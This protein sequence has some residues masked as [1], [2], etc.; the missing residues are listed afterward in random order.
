MAVADLLI[1]NDFV[2]H[3]SKGSTSTSTSS[4]TLNKQSGTLAISSLSV[5]SG[6]SS[7]ITFNNSLIKTGSVV[8]ATIDAYG[9]SSPF[10]NLTVEGITTGSCTLK[11]WNLNPAGSTLTSATVGFL[12]L[13]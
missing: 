5:S 1:N 6:T 11:L 10:P 4:V 2:L 8:L 3:C 9:G 7:N 12:V 13:Q